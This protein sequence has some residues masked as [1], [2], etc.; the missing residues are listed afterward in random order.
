MTLRAAGVLAAFLVAI[1]TGCGA[2]SQLIV[3][4]VG[5]DGDAAAPDAPA[6]PIACNA[7]NAYI[8]DC[9]IDF[10]PMHFWTDACSAGGCPPG[11]PDH[12]ACGNFN[13][14]HV[15]TNADAPGE[16]GFCRWSTGTLLGFPSPTL[17]DFS[18][19]CLPPALNPCMNLT[20]GGMPG[21]DPTEAQ[22]DAIDCGGPGTRIHDLWLA[23]MESWAAGC[24]SPTGTCAPTTPSICSPPPVVHC[25][26][27]NTGCVFCP[28]VL[29]SE[30]KCNSPPPACVPIPGP[31]PAENIALGTCVTAG[32]VCG[33]P[34]VSTS[35]PAVRPGAPH[36]PPT[37]PPEPFLAPLGGQRSTATI[38]SGTATVQIGTRAPV[39]TGIHGSVEIQGA[40]CPGRSC[41]VHF[42]VNWTFDNFVSA[43]DSVNEDDF[44]DVT[45]IGS[46]LDPGVD[47]DS[48]GSGVFPARGMLVTA[49]CHD[50]HILTG[51]PVR[52]NVGNGTETWS[53][54]N[55]APVGIHIDWVAHTFSLADEFMIPAGDDPGNAP[56]ITV[57]LNATAHI[58]NEPPT[59]V[60]MDQTIECTSPSGS[61]V[62][63]DASH[64]TD[65]DNNVFWAAWRRMPGG[66]VVA[67]L[68]TT[69][70][71]QPVGSATYRLEVRDSYFQE[72]TAQMTVHVGDTTP[73]TITSVRVNP[74]CLWPPNHNYVAFHLGDELQ[75][76]ASDTCSTP[77]VR[78]VDVTS[79]QPDSS[80]GSGSTL[81][82]VIFG[83][84]GFCVR[85][86]R[87]G[88][89]GP[90]TYTVRISA[91]DA[92]GNTTYA[93]TTVTVP[94]DQ[95]PIGCPNI[96][97]A[98]QLSDADAVTA[99]V[100][101]DVPGPAP[102]GMSPDAGT[103][104]PDAGASE[105]RRPER[106]D[107]RNDSDGS[108]GIGCSAGPPG[109]RGD[110]GL[111]LAG[112]AAF[113]AFGW[114]RR[115]GGAWVKRLAAIAGVL[116]AQFAAVGCNSQ[117][118]V[119]STEF[120][121]TSD[122]GT[123]PPLPGFVNGT[124]GNI[125]V[126]TAGTLYIG[127]YATAVIY[128][129]DSTGTTT[130]FTGDG[131]MRGLVDGPAHM[132]SFGRVCGMALDGLGNIVVAD[133]WSNA[134]RL[135]RIS[136]GS[137]STL[138]G[139]TTSGYTDGN[140]TSARFSA[141]WGVAVDRSSGHIYIGDSQNRVIRRIEPTAGQVVTIAGVAAG[142]YADGPG[143]SA[144][145]GSP[146][147]IAL[148]ANG[149][150]WIGDGANYV[151]RRV[152][153]HDPAF[154]VTTPTGVAGQS[155]YVEGSGH[156]SRFQSFYDI[157]LASSGA[158]IVTDRNNAVVR[159]VASDG[160]TTLLAGTPATYDPTRMRVDGPAT[161][162][163]FDGPAGLAVG[164]DGS[165]YV[166]DVYVVRRIAQAH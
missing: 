9:D 154:T 63:L 84:S 21:P 80:H 49:R 24:F 133:T 85:S 56:A 30:Q 97:Q 76:A 3:P 32:T 4:D 88:P 10:P 75:V 52:I 109:S 145:F 137:V 87:S 61:L 112:V 2:R 115:R 54:Y 98:E 155:G 134:I 39:S 8:C 11:V 148:D 164:A 74:S 7:H 43:H 106:R 38:V 122:G 60:A 77:V 144:R 82:D 42:G 37:T 163:V 129:V 100:F 113:C 162:A 153:L 157:A 128:R 40:P 135:V 14:G 70:I 119:V 130:V 126:D 142:G 86:E 127:D 111:I 16:A 18:R 19:T 81:H 50:D 72:S 6:H 58:G 71:T 147:P 83:Q 158:L 53:L 110:R 103:H 41:N 152:S 166:T 51:G 12:I 146:G 73:P 116:L 46:T 108:G 104:A 136:D 69:S 132:A 55:T 29:S 27:R 95:S 99:C 143:A 139:N 90:R 20:P 151:L 1:V 34:A 156:D 114:R 44:S 161:R 35:P 165:I 23:A 89:I 57:H 159:S 31:G 102:I 124:L 101:A 96:P 62:L 120:P 26:A 59:A 92:A 91:T 131:P 79:D 45:L 138:A 47:L 33:G 149:D 17:G 160:T 65:P 150:L 22:I 105:A 64:S 13:N 123:I 141:P 68:N 28:L 107:H 5:P 118:F 125:A 25:H 78:I 94:H 117:H 66:E 140:L 48:T 67:S 36:D 121:D 93:T 15:L